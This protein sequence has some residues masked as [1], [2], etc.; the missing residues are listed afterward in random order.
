MI[1]TEAWVIH[2]G[3]PT[4][5]PEP[6]ELVL[7]TFSFPDITEDELLVEPIYGCWEGNMTHTLRRSPIDACRLRGDS[8]VVVGNAGVVRVL[9][10]GEAIESAREGSLGIVSAVGDCDEA[11][12]PKTIFAY[13]APGTIG[14]LAKRTKLK[15]KNFF[16]IPE[17]T[18][19]SLKQWAAFSL[20]YPTAWDNWRVAYNCWRV[21][22]DEDVCPTPFVWGWGGGVTLAE[23]SLARFL[24]CRTAM[25]SSRDERLAVIRE[26]GVTPIDRRPFMGLCFDEKRYEADFAYRKKYLKAEKAFLSVVKEHTRGAGVSIFV[27]NIG[28]PVHRATL[29]ALGRQGVI[30]TVGWK[31]GMD[32]SVTRATE[33]IN[34]H[35]H[36]YTHGARYSSP[37]GIHFAEEKGWMPPIG[38]DVEVCDWGNIPRLAQKHAEGKITTYFPLYQVNPV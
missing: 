21:Q 15:E 4:R 17:N 10:V 6:A 20:R 11:G 1:T 9:K 24:G 8:K 26:L 16:P 13:D 29:K 35:I 2:Q 7:E 25:I 12:Y 3:P 34:R 23:V 18:K 32:L 36:V 37:I 22:M 28:A 27:D 14:L 30:T 5:E 33:C 38:D 19:Y 31:G